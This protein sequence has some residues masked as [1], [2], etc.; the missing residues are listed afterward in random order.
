MLG[1]TPFLLEWTPMRTP[2]LMLA[3][4]ALSFTAGCSTAT[5]FVAGAAGASRSMVQD[6]T[7]GR[8]ID[9]ATAAN[10]VRSKL[11]AMD[12][13]AFGGV[14]VEVAQGQLLLSGM[15]PS[16]ES[17][18]M[19]ERVAW[20]VP[21]VDE[22]ANE[23]VVGRNPSFMRSSLD[24]FMSAQVRAK[25]MSDARV[26]GVNFNIETH[27]GVVYLMGLARSEEE[28][29]RAAEDASNVRGVERVVSYVVVRPPNPM[30]NTASASGVPIERRGQSDAPAAPAPYADAGGGA[31]LP[32]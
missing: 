14:E 21:G 10:S 23:I 6:G 25:L 8:S 3:L 20:S 4:G 30:M 27:R 24:D 7:L 17:K 29:Q 28:L 18:A 15:A 22:V 11:M 9:D 16:P 13:A 31:P 26:K 1:I 19:A 12:R 5:G 32:R 2:A